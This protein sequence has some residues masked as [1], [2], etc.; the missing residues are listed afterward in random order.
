MGLR[1]SC[2]WKHMVFTGTAQVFSHISWSREDRN[3]SEPHRMLE[4]DALV[5]GTRAGAQHTLPNWKQQ[6]RRHKDTPHIPNPPFHCFPQASPPTTSCIPWALLV[7]AVLFSRA[8]H[9]PSHLSH[10]P[11]VFTQVHT[12]SLSPFQPLTPPSHPFPGGCLGLSITSSKGGSSM[13]LSNIHKTFLQGWTLLQTGV[14][15]CSQAGNRSMGLSQRISAFNREEK[16]C[17]A[18]GLQEPPPTGDKPSRTFLNSSTWPHRAS[19]S[20]WT[21]SATETSRRGWHGCNIGTHS[22]RVLLK[23]FQESTQEWN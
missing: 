9:P 2:I 5:P 21:A 11:V 18:P 7:G 4:M 8:Q 23:L 22:A 12:L 17:S 19:H 10:S 1:D 6:Q 15:L 14:P 20:Y 3:P 13:S 16:Q